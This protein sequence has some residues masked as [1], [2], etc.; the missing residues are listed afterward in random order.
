MSKEEAIA[1]A[2]RDNSY[3]WSIELWTGITFYYGHKITILEFNKHCNLF[4]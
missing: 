2:C 4:K 3:S 1:L